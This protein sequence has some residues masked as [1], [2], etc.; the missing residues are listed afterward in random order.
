MAMVNRTGHLVKSTMANGLITTWMALGFT[1]TTTMSHMRDSSRTIKSKVSVTTNGQTEG[2]IVAG[3]NKVS[4]M[5]LA[6]IQAVKKMKNT[7]F[8]NYTKLPHGFW[9][10]FL[11]GSWT[12]FGRFLGKPVLHHSCCAV[13]RALGERVHSKGRFLGKPALH[14]SCCAVVRALGERVHSNT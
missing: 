1:F 9:E 10:R 13:I 8:G 4:N 5:V 12:V 7:V 11:D 2:S 6:S 14:H 3:G